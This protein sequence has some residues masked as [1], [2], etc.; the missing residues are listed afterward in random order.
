MTPTEDDTALPNHAL[1]ILDLAKNVA[2]TGDPRGAGLSHHHYVSYH[3]SFIINGGLFHRLEDSNNAYLL[4]IGGL[5]R[6]AS[7]TQ[8]ILGG[9]DSPKSTSLACPTTSTP[10]SPNTPHLAEYVH[11]MH[12]LFKDPLSLNQS[13]CKSIW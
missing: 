7:V 10:P 11:T 12:T 6:T 1:P 9:M 4:T 13:A 2:A 3:L 8:V 5:G